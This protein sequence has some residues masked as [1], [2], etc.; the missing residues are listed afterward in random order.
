MHY[1]NDAWTLELANVGPD[2]ISGVTQALDR[3]GVAAIS[4]AAAG[5]TRMRLTLDPSA[6]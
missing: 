1:A 6:R 3:A 5:G 4:A 2:R